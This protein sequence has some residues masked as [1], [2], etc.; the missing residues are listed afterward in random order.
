MKLYLFYVGKP[1]DPN[2]NALAA[3][4]IKRADRFLRCEMREIKQA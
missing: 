2:A 4:Y 3:E 1:R